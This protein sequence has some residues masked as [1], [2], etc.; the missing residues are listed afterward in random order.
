[1]RASEPQSQ[2]FP[3]FVGPGPNRFDERLGVLAHPARDQ[4]AA[5]P[6][7]A[8]FEQGVARPA[9]AIEAERL[10]DRAELKAAA[11]GAQLGAA[12][13]VQG[14]AENGGE[15]AIQKVPDARNGRG[16]VARIDLPLG[17]GQRHQHAALV[18]RPGLGD[19][20]PLD[21][22]RRRLVMRGK[23]RIG[24]AVILQ[25]D[26]RRIGIPQGGHQV[27]FTPHPRDVEHP[28]NVGVRMALLV[29]QFANQ[30]RRIEEHAAAGV[31]RK[32]SHDVDARPGGA[33]PQVARRRGVVGGIL[34]TAHAQL[35]FD[36]LGDRAVVIDEG[37]PAQGAQAGVGLIA[38]DTV[39]QLRVEPGVRRQLAVAPLQ[40]MAGA[41]Q[42]CQDRF[43]HPQCG[44]LVAADR[45]VQGFRVGVDGEET[46]VRQRFG[47][48]DLGGEPLPQMRDRFDPQPTQADDER[49]LDDAGQLVR[50][51]AFRPRLAILHRRRACRAAHLL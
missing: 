21:R 22:R 47:H 44:A 40:V 50:G 37:E 38:R 5:Q 30:V 51:G 14:L 34:R 10:H 24:M 36:P 48:A 33:Q 41:L 1:M 2:R 16:V 12:L 13:F 3:A 32:R 19:P 8:L 26:Q 17:F 25:L 39:Q 23:N 4:L 28:N 11:G 27:R 49:R 43:L 45:L 46:E 15:I 6:A 42:L 29:E 7:S 20:F 35:P 18:R 9:D 31:S